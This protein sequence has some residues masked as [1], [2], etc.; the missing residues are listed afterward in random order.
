MCSQSWANGYFSGLP[1]V[2][3]IYF[4]L[5]ALRLGL[6]IRLFYNLYRTVAM[7]RYLV[8]VWTIMHFCSLW[9]PEK[10]WNLVLWTE[11]CRLSGSIADLYCK[12]WELHREEWSI[13]ES[14]LHRR[15]SPIDEKILVISF[16]SCSWS[17]ANRLRL[18]LLQQLRNLYFGFKRLQTF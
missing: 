3:Y 12:K 9:N 2:R 11:A 6:L 18:D 17:S 13:E 7:V 16:W 4:W 14:V 1:L 8:I 5:F 10:T 15:L